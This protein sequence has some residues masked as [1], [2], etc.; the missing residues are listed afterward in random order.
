MELHKRR[1][2]ILEPECRYYMGQTNDGVEY[3]HDRNIVHRDLKLGNVFLDDKLKCKIGDFGLAAQMDNNGTPRKTMCGTPNYLAPEILQ[4]KGHNYQVDIW[5]LGCMLY[6][7]IVGKPPF[8]T[9]TL[10]ETY[11]RIKSNTYTI[12]SH[13]S[14]E[15]KKIITSMLNDDPAA[16]PKIKDLKFMQW[17]TLWTPTE[18]PT[19]AL[20]TEPRFDEEEN[21]ENVR[22]VAVPAGVQQNKA[23]MIAEDSHRRAM[24]S[25]QRIAAEQRA[26]S[27][28]LSSIRPK[29]EHDKDV[30]AEHLPSIISQ[31]KELVSKRPDRYEVIFMDD[32]EKP[33]LQPLF[34]IT[35]W[36]DFQEKYGF[37]YAL[38]EG[39]YGVNFRDDERTVLNANGNNLMYINKNNTE[40]HYSKKN[41]D[42]PEDRNLVKKIQLTDHFITYMRENLLTAGPCKESQGDDFA[43]IPYLQKWQRVSSENN[44]L[45]EHQARQQSPNTNSDCI[46]FLLT[47]GTFQCNFHQSHVKLIV[48]PL[49][50]AVT[51]LDYGNYSGRTFSL[52]DIHKKGCDRE[53][54]MYIR[55]A[56]NAAN[57]F[58]R[59]YARERESLRRRQQNRMGGAR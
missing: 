55:Y 43:R 26:N 10:K 2:R 41:K 11:S 56:L 54:F 15:A 12:P 27:R 34:W 23:Q 59:T 25:I 53:P 20:S 58:Q 35:K 52:D 18:L 32:A 22:P 8:E 5:S 36:V 21:I 28:R 42:F 51:F 9:N 16:R 24:A 30:F 50:K 1:G 6:T 40:Y 7:L 19:S 57:V 4:K 3:L 29:K 46:G 17:F 45:P 31:L 38:A 48:C 14:V 47:N 39:H 33:E 44:V 49:M 13:T 37:G